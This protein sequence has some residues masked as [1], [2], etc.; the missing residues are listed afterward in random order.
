MER[1]DLAVVGGSAAGMAAA[2]HAA[3]RDPKQRI[4]LLEKLP[5]VGKKLLATGNGRCNLT[6]LQ[7]SPG[8][9]HNGAF[10][11]P[12]LAAYPPQAVL[13]FFQRH[14]L[15]AYADA[16]GRVYPRSNV[17]ASVVDTLRY[18]LADAGVEVRC[19]TPVT[20]IRRSGHGFL[21]NE[22]L[23]ADTVILAAGGQAAPVHGSDGSGYALA[24]QLGHSVTALAPALVPLIAAPGAT[25]PLKG[26]RAHDAAL[27]LISGG[28]RYA[29]TAGE[30][31]FTARGLSGIA[32]MELAAAAQTALKNDKQITFTEIDFLPEMAADAL[33]NELKKSLIIKKNQPMDQLLTGL[34]PK[35]IGVH[36]CKA[37]KLYNQET[38]VGSLTDRQLA[39][40]AGLLKA[41]RVQI[42]GVGSFADAQVT[43]GGVSVREIDP[44]TLQSLRQPGLYFA[45][46]LIDVDGPCGGYNLQWAFA[47]GL[48]AGE[49]KG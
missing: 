38:R 19:E 22:N 3:E 34:V 15:R 10:A 37:A 45:G 24:R 4:L 1:F 26:V 44:A 46:E 9:Y 17:A 18:A 12:A 11:A 30:L 14:G 31:L 6:N 7:A 49:R 13:A 41:F 21:L 5:R 16:A 36:I 43:R 29:Q 47:S 39:Q 20:S 8:A 23:A 25:A 2:I 48:V 40:L 42:T 35:M 28:R 27:T 32:A 33:R